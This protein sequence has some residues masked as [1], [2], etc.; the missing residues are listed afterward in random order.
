[1]R[2]GVS[3]YILSP[4]VNVEIFRF[5]ISTRWQLEKFARHQV[6]EAV[7]LPARI[8]KSRCGQ[9]LRI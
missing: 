9:I 1:M 6:R 4:F 7:L 8:V 5:L 2:S 3:F